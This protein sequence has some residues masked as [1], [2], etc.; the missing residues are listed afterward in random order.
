MR[1]VPMTAAKPMPAGRSAAD[2]PNFRQTAFALEALVEAAPPGLYGAY[3][4][5][6]APSV[7]RDYTRK[8]IERSLAQPDAHANWSMEGKTATGL[9]VW[10]RL[11]WDS[12]Q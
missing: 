5:L 9:A 2:K 8:L 3:P 1:R 6:V 11:A 7:A 10:S 4:D 12:E